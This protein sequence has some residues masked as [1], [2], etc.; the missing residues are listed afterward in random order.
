LNYFLNYL[1]I[2]LFIN[3]LAKECIDKIDKLYE[4]DTFK[5]KT[6]IVK[7]FLDFYKQFVSLNESISFD[8]EISKGDLEE[9]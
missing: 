7:T 3:S 6:K 9:L 1:I 8:F 2:N 4:F 5:K